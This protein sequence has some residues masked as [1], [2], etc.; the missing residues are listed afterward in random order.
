MRLSELQYIN[1]SIILGQKYAV[2]DYCPQELIDYTKRMLDQY[3][4]NPQEK[5]LQQMRQE[6][7]V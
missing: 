6:A 2:T 4:E 5:I 1:L 7:S 3:G